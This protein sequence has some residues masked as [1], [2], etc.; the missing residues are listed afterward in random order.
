MLYTD[1]HPVLMR[2]FDYFLSK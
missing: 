2:F 1:S